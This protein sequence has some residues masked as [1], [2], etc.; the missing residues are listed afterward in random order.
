MIHKHLSQVPGTVIEKSGFRGMTARFALTA[1]DGCPRYAMRVMEFE[2][3]G[4]TSLHSHPEEHEFYFLEG[5]AA[6][7]GADG[8]EVE[9]T[10]G[11]MIYVAPGEA[12][13]L[14]N[15]GCGTMRVVCTIPIL[16]G[17]DGKTTGHGYE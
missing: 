14:K 7:V 2:P 1:D 15:V 3:G 11:S 13:Q 6:V 16:P 17:G 10:S 9:A 5:K 12:H 8:S 4:Y